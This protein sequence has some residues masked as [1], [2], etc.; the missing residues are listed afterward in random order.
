MSRVMSLLHFA[1]YDVSEWRFNFTVVVRVCV[2]VCVCVCVE[3]TEAM[4]TK[5]VY[6]AVCGLGVMIWGEIPWMAIFC[7]AETDVERI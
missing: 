7:R 2:C 5:V 3:K 1:S 6:V 4:L